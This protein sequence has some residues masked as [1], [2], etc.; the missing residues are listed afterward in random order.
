MTRWLLFVPPAGALLA[1][2]VL[3]G[4]SVPPTAPPLDCTPP[5][6]PPARTEV[7]GGLVSGDW[8]I[9]RWEPPPGCE[10]RVP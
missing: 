3:F 5:E 6:A 2:A 8:T 1:L 9:T 7:V 4:C 10:G